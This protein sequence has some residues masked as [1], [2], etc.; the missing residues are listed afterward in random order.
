MPP[1]IA[2]G[3]ARRERKTLGVRGDQIGEAW[4][5]DRD[6][7]ALQ[8]GDAI[9]ENVAND[10]VVPEL[11]EAG[12][13]DEPT[14]PAPKTRLVKAKRSRPSEKSV[15]DRR[16]LGDPYLRAGRRPF[17]MASIVSLGRRSRSVLTTQ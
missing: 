10:D 8:R 2:L 7:T 4:L 11:G 13:G 3:D 5:E 14:Y 9:S 1:W 12:A 6:L 17:A 16:P 15:R